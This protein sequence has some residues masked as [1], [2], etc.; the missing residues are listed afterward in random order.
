LAAVLTV[1][2]E[3]PEA[4]TGFLEK[5]A[6]APEGRPAAESATLPVNPFWAE[7]LTE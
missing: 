1:S 5:V 7:M 3:V 6:L 2:V 4:A